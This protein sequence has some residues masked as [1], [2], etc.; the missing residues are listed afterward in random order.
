MLIKIDDGSEVE[1]SYTGRFFRRSLV[2]ARW[3]R[4]NK[5]VVLCVT[6]IGIISLWIKMK[7][8]MYYLALSAS[9]SVDSDNK[10]EI[11]VTLTPLAHVDTSEEKSEKLR[12][13]LNVLGKTRKR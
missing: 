3:V 10:K 9:S 4:V 7:D 11:N 12:K 13:T 6:E 8:G 1:I 5:D 2:F